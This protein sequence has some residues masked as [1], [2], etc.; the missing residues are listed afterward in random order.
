VKRHIATSTKK[1][2]PIAGAMS[3][4]VFSKLYGEITPL[5]KGCTDIIK[6]EAVYKK[7]AQ[8]ITDIKILTA[9]YVPIQLFAITAL[10]MAQDYRG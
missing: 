3:F 10:V 9:R 2:K 8:N 6:L 5:S 7:L 4:D 1:I